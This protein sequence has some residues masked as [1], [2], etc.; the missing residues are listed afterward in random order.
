MLIGRRMERLTAQVAAEHFRPSF[1]I[2]RTG[3]FIKTPRARTKKI[4]TEMPGNHSEK[5]NNENT[6]ER[7]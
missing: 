7:Y 2:K 1:A 5:I 3:L 4:E 6:F